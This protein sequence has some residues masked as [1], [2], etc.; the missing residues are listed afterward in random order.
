MRSRS[1]TT[2]RIDR[3]HR[4][5]AIAD[6]RIAE[7]E[8]HIARAGDLEAAAVTEAALEAERDELDAMASR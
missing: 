2:E 4:E 1:A 7:L 6:Q 8:E 5:L 3:L